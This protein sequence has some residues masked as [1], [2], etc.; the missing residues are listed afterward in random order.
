[1]A[2]TLISNF[3]YN[4]KQPNFERD[5]VATVSELLAVDPLQQ[6][7]DY[8][9]IV[10]CVEDGKHY[11]F[12]YNYDAP[13]DANYN[14]TTGWFQE[15]T[16]GS[17]EGS[18][19]TSNL[20]TKDELKAKQ[21]AISDLGTIRSGAAKGAT[22]VQEI[23]LNN[24]PVA[25]P[26]DGK[27]ILQ[28][29]TINN[30]S[31]TG[32]GNIEIDSGSSGGGII[33]ETDPVFKASAA[34]NINQSDIDSWNNKSDFSGNYN[35]LSNK[36]TIPSAVTE[37]TIS[38]W[39]FT[40]N[41][42]TVTS[43]KINGVTKSP[44]ASG[45]VDLGSIESGGGTT[46]INGVTDVIVDGVTVVSDN[47]ATIPLASTSVVGVVQ[48]SSAVDS[49]SET[50]AATPAAVKS[51]NDKVNG[52]Q[53][54][55]S[56][57]AE[58]RT[59]ASNA[60]KGTINGETTGD[61]D[62]VTSVNGVSPN[63]G[64]VTIDVGD[65][66][67]QSDW[68]ATS[69]DAYIKN[70]PTIPTSLSQ[71]AEDVSHRTVTDSEKNGW[72][73]KLDKNTADNSYLGKNDKATSATNADN[74]T[75]DGNGD[76]ISNTYATK[77]ALSD[78]LAGKANIADIPDAVTEDTVRDWGFTK[79]TGTYSKPTGG[80]P[81][82]DL[83]SNVQTIL[84]KANMAID[85]IV[86]NDVDYAPSG[87][88][89]HIDLGTV[90]TGDDS[91]Q[92]I[93]GGL[94]VG[95]D[96]TPSAMQDDKHIGRVVLTGVDNPLVGLL[97]NSDGAVPFYLQAYKNELYVGQTR[98]KAIKIN[99]SGNVTVQKALAV[100]NTISEGGV[101]LS[102]KYQA[103]L[104][105]GTNIKTINNQSIL[106]SGN[107]V[108]NAYPLV[109][110]GT[111]DTTF[112]LTPNTFHVWGTVSSL[113]LTFGSETEGVA[114]EYLFQFSCSSSVA[115]TLSLPSSVMWADGETPAIEVM[116]TYQV[117]ILN[118]CATIQSFG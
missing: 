73:A 26:T 113:T 109:S 44:N 114:N 34:A 40:K 17:G 60:F 2:T 75:N 110:H 82:G 22:S 78:G 97:D 25:Q 104:V 111:S 38:N 12:M 93:L 71:L 10:F 16:T 37:S 55:I 68:N 94:V 61:L 118:N 85:R 115:T 27:V 46:V 87:S 101:D 57:I 88:E 4:G 84:G 102:N 106:G 103:K 7:Y 92:H 41:N 59:N 50:K 20:A 3:S 45:V 117:S 69:G 28:F 35:D 98:G 32:S 99:S 29:K 67:I 47:V 54:A 42:G 62:V 6:K 39:G 91:V 64:A 23:Q 116:K 107:I 24:D 108:A 96:T 72:D 43:V 100:T 70:K 11:R 90:I 5:R 89:T 105:S 49:D 9:H 65:K 66:N 56:D 112:T 36:P 77:A 1:M 53:D 51:V 63:R 58:I 33:S 80:I 13:D 14:T 30:K 76:N 19:D 31:I 79:N 52:K 21:D 8:G 81:F 48:L 18:I 15:L 86:M 83:D 74:A 95:S